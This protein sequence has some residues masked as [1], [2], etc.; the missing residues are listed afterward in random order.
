M[1]LIHLY[2]NIS[3]FTEENWKRKL[4]LLVLDYNPLSFFNTQANHL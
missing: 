2:F 1:W 4:G 3:D